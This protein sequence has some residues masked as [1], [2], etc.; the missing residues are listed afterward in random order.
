MSESALPY[1]G[2]MVKNDPELLLKI[3]VDF[4]LDDSDLAFL[5]GTS[6]ESSKVQ[7]TLARAKVSS[8]R[9]EEP[10]GS[11]KPRTKRAAG[12]KGAGHF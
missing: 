9:E 11:A 4:E 5:L 7:E 10:G 3:T 8:G 2:V 12:K 1:L 6:P